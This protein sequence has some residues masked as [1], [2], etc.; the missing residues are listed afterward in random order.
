MPN[1][2]DNSMSGDDYMVTSDRFSLVAPDGRVF[3]SRRS[4]EHLKVV[5]DD[6]M[7][8]IPEDERIYPWEVVSRELVLRL[9]ITKDTTQK[10]WREFSLNCQMALD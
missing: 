1:D 10:D 5:F 9:K 2:N 6:Y 3:A 7:K 4:V 8:N